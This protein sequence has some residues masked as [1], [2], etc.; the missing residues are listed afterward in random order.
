MDGERR[1]W[2]AGER[3]GGE[4]E[5]VVVVAGGGLVVGGGFVGAGIAAS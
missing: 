2:I 5:E 3:E 1:A 4:G